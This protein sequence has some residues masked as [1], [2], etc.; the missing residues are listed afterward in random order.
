MTPHIPRQP[1]TCTEPTLA[2]CLSHLSLTDTSTNSKRM[3]Y[4]LRPRLFIDY[5]NVSLCKFRLDWINPPSRLIM[6]SH[7]PDIVTLDNL[8]QTIT[9]WNPQGESQLYAIVDMG[10]YK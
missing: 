5:R 8:S 7:A 10:R 3:L 6:T 2:L 1:Q 9:P 4:P